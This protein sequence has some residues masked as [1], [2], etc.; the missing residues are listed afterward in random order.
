MPDHTTARV[1]ARLKDERVKYALEA[2]DK[3][4]RDL[5]SYGEAAGYNAG[6][7]RAVEVIEEV[8]AEEAGDEEEI[9]T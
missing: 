4:K 2:L 8:L 6:L 5:F 3:P 1:I 7:H 9:E